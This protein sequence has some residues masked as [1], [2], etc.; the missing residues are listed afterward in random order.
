MITRV[1]RIC[2]VF[3][4]VAALAVGAT[5]LAKR[6]GGGGGGC[7][8]APKGYVCPA[9]YAPVVCGPDDCFYS[10]DCWASLAGWNVATECTPVGP[11]PIPFP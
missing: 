6:P 9:Y 10:N 2:F 8:T 11:G 5:A 4:V 1:L 3:T 7:P